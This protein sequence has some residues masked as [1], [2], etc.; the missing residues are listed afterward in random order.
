M[1]T[2]REE[3]Q[4]QVYGLE[5]SH[6]EVVHDLDK[7]VDSLE[8]RVAASEVAAQQKIRACETM[9]MAIT[10]ELREE[11]QSASRTIALAS[12]IGPAAAVEQRYL[13]KMTEMEYQH[14]KA[15][16]AW[17]GT[18]GARLAAQEAAEG[19]AKAAAEG[20]ISFMNNEYITMLERAAQ[21]DVEKSAL[22]AKI[23]LSASELSQARHEAETLRH[24]LG[25]AKAAPPFKRPPPA[26][27]PPPGIGAYVALPGMGIEAALDKVRAENI[28]RLATPTVGGVVPKAPGPTADHLNRFMAKFLPPPAPKASL[29]GP[30]GSKASG[31][32]RAAGQIGRSPETTGKGGG[33]RRDVGPP[34]GDPPPGDDDPY[35]DD[36]QDEEED[37]PEDESERTPPPAKRKRRIRERKGALQLPTRGVVAMR[38]PPRPRHPR[39]PRDGNRS[40][41]R[42]RRRRGRPRMP[43]A[44]IRS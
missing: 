1:V 21:R 41:R 44:M 39:R 24:E 2:M 27:P 36:E 11:L 22:V 43:R 40:A 13:H 12:A 34:G 23:R 30:S 10:R 26:L 6:A 37:A 20:C 7:K 4:S 15:R 16:E 14:D 5:Q 35:D 33:T 18:L 19:A 31:T 3:A 32:S 42:R 9:E 17:E 38:T 29:L 8:R 25:E 28:A